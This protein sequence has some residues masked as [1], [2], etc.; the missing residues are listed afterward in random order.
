MKDTPE[1][2]QRWF[3]WHA[4]HLAFPGCASTTLKYENMDNFRF[5]RITDTAACIKYEEQRQKGCC[6][7]KD[8]TVEDGEGN[9]WVIGFNYGH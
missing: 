3:E 4:E 5:A 6:G 7:G 2:I 1:F 8:A 9:L